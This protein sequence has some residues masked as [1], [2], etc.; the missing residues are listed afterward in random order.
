MPCHGFLN[1]HGG[2]CPC[3]FRALF[4]QKQSVL[5]KQRYYELPQG[6][7]RLAKKQKYC[8][9]PLKV[10]LITFFLQVPPDRKR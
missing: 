6:S 10:V 3:P 5:S 9:I 2:S 1:I 7:Y 4:F 8:H